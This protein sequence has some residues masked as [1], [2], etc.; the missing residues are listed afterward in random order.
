[1]TPPVYIVCLVIV[2][3]TSDVDVLTTRIVLGQNVYVS[4]T[5]AAACKVMLTT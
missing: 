2:F 3:T 4:A 5:V 1:M